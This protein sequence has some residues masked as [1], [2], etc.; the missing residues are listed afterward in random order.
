METMLMP[1]DPSAVAGAEAESPTQLA[2]RYFERLPKPTLLLRPDGAIARANA[3]ARTLLLDRHCLRLAYGRV[4][5]FAGSASERFEDACARAIFSG[6]SRVVITMPADGA[7]MWQVEL[8][9]LQIE[10]PGDMLLMATVHAPVRPER[11]IVALARIF[12]LT[13]AESRVLAHLAEDRTPSE[14]GVVLGV[15]VTTVRSHLQALFQKT[16]VRRQP[17]LVRLTLLAA[18]S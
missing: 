11:G 15:S 4:V 9:S 2:L 18:S 7:Q 6:A 1:A 14:I 5:G 8:V 10:T 17:E 12:G 16:G 3:A 13:C